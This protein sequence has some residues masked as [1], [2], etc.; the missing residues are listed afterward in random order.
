MPFF[1]P[2]WVEISQE[3]FAS[4]VRSLKKFIGPSCQILAVLK[5][6]AYGHHAASLASLAI[7]NGASL[8]GVSSIEEAIS[9]RESGYKDSLLI[10]GG[11]YPFENFSAV[12]E[13]D[14]I[15]TVA[16]RESVLFLKKMAEEKKRRYPFHLKIDTGMGRI[17]MTVESAKK[18]IDEFGKDEAV[19]LAGIY[20]HFASAGEDVE[21]TLHQLEL[22][23]DLEKY[24]MKS[25][26]KNVFFH[27]ANSAGT[28]LFPQSH[29]NLVRPGVALYGIQNI[30]LPRSVELKPVLSWKSK[31]IFL[32]RVPAGTPISYGRSFVTKNESEIMTVPVGYADGIPRSTLNKAMVLVKGERRPILGRVTMDHIMVDVTGLNVSIGEEVVMIGRQGN[33]FIS[34]LDWAQ[35]AGTISYEIV[36][37]ISKRVPRMVVA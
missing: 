37:G 33:G 1:R 19:Q 24:V 7:K 21:F 36:C 18:F 30:P 35:W 6:D 11:I 4:N 12:F 5:A 29:L 27:M 16:S 2:T 23:K 22:F 31:A 20:S 26:I 10:L 8:L 17:G 25:E 32:K 14:L 34:A 13:Y 9:L 3:A 15:P 28:I